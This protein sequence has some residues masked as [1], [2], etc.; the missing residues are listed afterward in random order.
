MSSRQKRVAALCLLVLGVMVLFPPQTNPALFEDGQ[1]LTT[2][3]QYGFIAE[4]EQIAYR[5]LG[6]QA[7][8]VVLVGAAYLVATDG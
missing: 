1:L 4:A 2:S 3:I 7:A 8:A 5:R 6:L